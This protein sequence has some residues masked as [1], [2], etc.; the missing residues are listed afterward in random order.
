[1]PDSVATD[2]ASQ[3]KDSLKSDTTKTDTAQ[4]DF[5]KML[6][7]TTSVRE[8]LFT[9]RHSEDKYFFTL[10]DSLLG[11]YLLTVTRYTSVP[12][13]FGEFAG[14]EVNEATVYFERRD[15]ATLFL[16]AYVL[17][18]LADSTHR[19]AKTLRMSTTDPIVAVLKTLK[20][21]PKGTSTF[22][23]T[24]LFKSDDCLMGLDE[25]TIKDKKM[26]SLKQ[27]RCFVDTVKTFPINVEVQST[28]TYGAGTNR[29]AASATG[30][31]TLG[32]NTSILLLPKE[33]MQQRLW[34]S[35]V[36]Y[37]TNRVSYFSDDQ[38]KVEHEQF[39][40]RYRLVPKDVKRYLRGELTE[41]VEPIV[42]YIDPATPKKWVPYLIA[43]INDWNV[44]FEAAG[45]K[46]AIQGREWPDDPDMSVDDAR[47]C[48]LR[49]LP[50]EIENAYGPHVSDPRSGEIV[51]SH[52]GWYHNVMNLLTN[53]YMTQCGAVDKRAQTLKMDDE[54]MG[55]LIRFVSSHEV[56]HTLGLRHNM[57]SSSLT[58]VEKLRDKKWVEANGHTASIMDYARFNYVAQPEDGIS[59]RGLFPRI[60]EYDKWAIKWGY[61]YR[62]EFKSAQEE[63]EPLMAETT[64]ALAANPRLWFGGE[65]WDEDPRAQTEDLSDDNMKASEYGL[66]NLQRIIQG[67][68]SWTA[69]SNYRYED[70]SEAYAS[71]RGQY[72]RYEGHVLKNI[73]GHYLN[74]M[75]DRKPVEVA[76]KD[77]QR[78]AL[79]YIADYVFTTPE[80]LY[81]TEI[82]E[83]TGT[84][85]TN[86]ITS[87]QDEAVNKIYSLW[88]L[89][90]IYNDSF[91]ADDNYQLEDY[92]SDVFS[93]VWT[94]PSGSTKL[95]AKSRRALQRSVV[96]V[97]SSLLEPQKDINT[98]AKRSYNSDVIPYLLQHLDRIDQFATQHQ[99]SGIEGAHFSDIHER[100]SL[101]KK[102]RTEL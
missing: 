70:L 40:A 31:I 89:N 102:R 73:G 67:L 20:G 57:G 34:D 52:I 60:G 33:P 94:N 3:P 22:D 37:F 79:Q 18:Q 82:T 74:N 92:L 8:G 47:F 66:K 91:L 17:T 96:A 48:V 56:G 75:P 14:E 42:Y 55:Q 77:K 59:E 45:F 61:Q 11:R 86:E 93:I 38:H 58:P 46:N 35:R 62:P 50:A 88:T 36:G 25:S 12:Q 71:V 90:R 51:E 95:Q 39:I 13:N 6:K 24:P 81:P 98:S 64:K 32:L 84:D 72:Q 19:I 68:P 78:R 87:R 26:G 97:L 4:S 99:G 69:Q 16:R 21:S 23:A 30:V 54:L 29:S 5:D 63:K 9:V 10:P 15:S 80:W 44:A 53:W 100:I 41:P 2:T 49:Y 1:M 28:R 65:G 76:P 43:G 85:V 7:K 27:D 101:I 83:K